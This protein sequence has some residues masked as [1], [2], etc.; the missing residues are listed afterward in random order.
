M[1][2]GTL[3]YNEFKRMEL[4]VGTVTSVEPHPNADKLYVLKVNVGAE[5]RQLVAGLRPYYTPEQLQGK[6]LVIVANLEPAKLRGVESQGMLLAAQ[7][8]DKPDEVVIISPE[9]PMAPGTRVL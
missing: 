2:E 8:D 3:S 5:E 6:Q 7:H 1:P 4:V 9:R